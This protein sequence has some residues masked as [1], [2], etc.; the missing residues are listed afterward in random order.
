MV[1]NAIL[2]LKVKKVGEMAETHVRGI[3]DLE[4]HRTR[5]ETSLQER[6]I[7]IEQHEQLARINVQAYESTRVMIQKKIYECRTR[8]TMVLFFSSLSSVKYDFLASKSL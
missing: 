7:E 5:L 8:V 6:R 4:M 3:V 1:E 2:K